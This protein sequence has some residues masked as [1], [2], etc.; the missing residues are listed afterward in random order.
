MKAA[1]SGPEKKSFENHLYPT[2]Y[3][4]HIDIALSTHTFSD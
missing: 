1:Q 2:D 4:V 3:N